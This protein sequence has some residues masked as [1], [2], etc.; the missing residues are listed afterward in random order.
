MQTSP[1][2]DHDKLVGLAVL[3]SSAEVTDEQRAV[4]LPERRAPAQ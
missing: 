2:P 1:Q 4:R 3:T